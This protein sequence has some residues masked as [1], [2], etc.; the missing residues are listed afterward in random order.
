MATKR[1]NDGDRRIR[2]KALI[3]NSGGKTVQITE[4]VLLQNMDSY[5][6][7]WRAQTLMIPCSPDL[8]YQGPIGLP[9]LPEKTEKSHHAHVRGQEN[10][11]KVLKLYHEFSQQNKLKWKI[12]HDVHVKDLRWDKFAKIF[13][14]FFTSDCQTVIKEHLEIDVVVVEGTS[15]I[16]TEVKSSLPDVEIMEKPLDQ[17]KKGE[18]FV[19]KIID[20]VGF[21]CC[22]IKV[23]AAPLPTSSAELNAKAIKNNCILLD[24]NEQIDEQR[25]FLSS[26]FENGLTTS[27]IIHDKLVAAF[28]FLKCCSQLNQPFEEEKLRVALLEGAKV[29]ELSD[30]LTHHRPL[31]KWKHPDVRLSKDLHVWLDP[32]QVKIM[33]DKF[34]KQ[35]IMGPAS[36]GKT[37]LVQLKILEKLKKDDNVVVILPSSFLVVKYRSFYN[38]HFFP[39]KLWIGKP[40]E[41]WQSVVQK[42]KS[43][44]FIDEFCSS[45]LEHENFEDEVKD[46]SNSLSNSQLLWITMDL[47]QGLESQWQF[48]SPKGVFFLDSEFFRKSQ[49]TMIHRCTSNVLKNYFEYCGSLAHIGHQIQGETTQT[50]LAKPQKG[51]IMKKFLTVWAL[52]VKKKFKEQIDRKGYKKEDIA[53]I[54]AIDDVDGVLLFQELRSVMGDVSIYFECQTLSHEWPV[55]IVCSTKIA[56]KQFSY[57]AFSRAIFKVINV[58]K[59]EGESESKKYLLSKKLLTVL[60]INQ[61]N[62][63]LI[64]PITVDMLGFRQLVQTDTEPCI[65]FGYLH[66]DLDGTINKLNHWISVLLKYH[67]DLRK[68]KL[69]AEISVV[70]SF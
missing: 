8:K 46:I 13:G 17:L 70:S 9:G 62:P 63:F 61:T 7:G 10:E 50:I 16:L 24:L 65:I 52:E 69:W 45:A 11:V 18:D 67:K 41:D 38:E 39:G 53:I 20:I 14:N 15:I 37:I 57:I 49:L 30:D 56:S 54:I 23:I 22:I 66:K 40:D 43:H 5:Y 60:K 47:K 3:R 55:V 35:V 26:A 64:R 44:I 1:P 28:A 68:V 4:N 33:S 48:P 2:P 19:S 34:P 42:T 31:E 51:K 25:S 29:K 21:N 59:P 32:I 58:I 27:K 12:F 6:P 36:T